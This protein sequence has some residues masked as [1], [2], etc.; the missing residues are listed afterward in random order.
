[1][2][3][4]LKRTGTRTC[5]SADTIIT[6]SWPDDFKEHTSYLVLR[7]E[8]GFTNNPT[9]TRVVAPA[10]RLPV[11]ERRGNVDECSEGEVA[12]TEAK[13]GEFAITKRTRESP[14]MY[15]AIPGTFRIRLAVDPRHKPKKPSEATTSLATRITEVR[16]RSLDTVSWLDVIPYLCSTLNG[17][18][19]LLEAE[20]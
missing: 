17:R 14:V 19:H 4:Q 12:Q 3:V 8:K 18:N 16:L 10:I 9:P 5:Y 2:L 6:V 20:S 15:I 11:L 13:Y 7:T 1:M